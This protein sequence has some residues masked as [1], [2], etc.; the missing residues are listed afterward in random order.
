MRN[1]DKPEAV[2]FFKERNS[3]GVPS[4]HSFFNVQTKLNIS[5]A[6]DP[7]EKQ[8]DAM[9]DKVMQPSPVQRQ[10]AGEETQTKRLQRQKEEDK[11]QT[12]LQKQAAEEEKTQTKLQ[13]AGEEE[14]QTKLLRQEEEM[15]SKSE[16]SMQ[17]E[18]EQAQ[19]KSEISRQEEEEQAQTKPLLQRKESMPVKSFEIRL[20]ENK[21]GGISLPDNLKEE[22]EQKFG[23]RFNHVRIHADENAAALC[24]EI[25]AQ[26]FTNGNHIFFNKD[27]YD[28]GSASG[29]HLLAHELTHVV[30]QEKSR[31]R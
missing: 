7:M 15:Q 30:Q 23:Y 25:N 29:K 10:T 24:E 21:S 27:K 12:K 1:Q 5:K 3:M 16:I 9:A 8:A 14:T 11:T 17:E 19:T 20:S 4:G 31:E 18:V 6:G 13:R 22:M 26:A 2:S 28:P